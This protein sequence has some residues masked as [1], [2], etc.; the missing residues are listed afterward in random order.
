[1][2]GSVLVVDDDAAMVDLLQECL[3]EAGHAVRTASS[4]EQ[5]VEQA[6]RRPVDVLLTDLRMKGM[7]GM[8]LLARFREEWPHTPVIV[9]TGFGSVGAAVDAM[10]AG[11]HDF[12]AKP[13]DLDQLELVVERAV[14]HRAM[15][16]ELET[17]RS[18]ARS[19]GASGII[20]DSHAMQRVH[21]IVRRAARSDAPVLITGETGTGKELVARA[22]HD[23]SP[24]A[25]HP[26]VAVNCAALPADLLESE[27]FGH[28]RGAFTGA[29]Q[30][31]RGLF[32]EAGEGTL[33]LDELGELPLALQPKLLRVLQGGGMRAVG[34]D[35]EIRVRCRV[36]AA[37]HKD[38]VEEVA[39]GGFRSDLYYRLAVV[40]ITVPALRERDGDVLVLAQHFL[41][42]AARRLGRPIE[43]IEPAAGR[44]LL[45]H[46]WP[47]NV[48]E[49]E[50]AIEAAVALTDGPS[51]SL[52]DLPADLAGLP[53][54]APPFA[55]APAP[56]ALRP[57]ADV[58]HEHILAVIAAVDGNKLEA[59]RILGI[60][61]RTLYRKLERYGGD[62]G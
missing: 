59:A 37:T 1:M 7:D 34:A 32:L 26:F 41:S 4:A 47:G 39:A 18:R 31:R 16:R 61:R 24:R 58:E 43:G 13:V 60:D 33:L 23:A 27:L 28:T 52:H 35:R 55:P 14:A 53:H 19:Q 5:A 21:D 12:L 20:G 42:R 57:L 6:R 54:P 44:A 40:R 51:I 8:A 30:A 45:R 25:A 46:R 22:L 3:S 9:L 62:P 17:L 10:R 50:N 56:A 11:A 15:Q 38:L 2:K 36:I 29:N 49:L 48:R